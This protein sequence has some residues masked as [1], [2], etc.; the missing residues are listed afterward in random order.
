MRVS[1][2]NALGLGSRGGKFYCEMIAAK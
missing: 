1:T 2:N